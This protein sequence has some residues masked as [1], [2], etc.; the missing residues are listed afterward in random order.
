MLRH[1][2]HG[3]GSTGQ[4][5]WQ[6]SQV[7]EGLLYRSRKKFQKGL[8]AKSNAKRK[9]NGQGRT[10]APSSKLPGG[11]QLW[12]DQSGAGFGTAA[13]AISRSH[14]PRAGQAVHFCVAQGDQPSLTPTTIADIQSTTHTHQ[15]RRLLLLRAS[16]SRLPPLPKLPGTEH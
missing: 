15:R 2:N 3:Q 13:S 11:S 5:S 9:C 16:P 14:S 8:E 12:D 10:R 6:L 7:S 1:L 4:V